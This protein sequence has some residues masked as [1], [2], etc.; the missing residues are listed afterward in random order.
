MAGTGKR[1]LFGTGIRWLGGKEEGFFYRYP[2]TDDPVRE[3][4]VLS[5]IEDLKVPLPGRTTG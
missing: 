4:R 2:G 3:G 5:R 1:G